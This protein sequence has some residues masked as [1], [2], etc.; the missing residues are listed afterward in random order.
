MVVV[1]QLSTLLVRSG[2]PRM[3]P[4]VP[5]SLWCDPSSHLFWSS[6]NLLPHCA[7]R[8]TWPSAKRHRPA[9]A[10]KVM[11][12]IPNAFYLPSFSPFRS[13]HGQLCQ[14]SKLSRGLLRRQTCS[15]HRTEVLS[16]LTRPTDYCRSVETGAALTM[17]STCERS[18]ALWR[19]IIC[20][21]A[22]CCFTC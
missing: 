2:R 18:P 14:G 16:C 6:N 19:P 13:A 1:A 15:G 4:S 21:Y 8:V 12:S 5:L 7:A 9:A 11:Q 17:T 22:H 3:T 20:A 10:I